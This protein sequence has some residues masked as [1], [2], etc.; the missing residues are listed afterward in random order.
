MTLIQTKQKRAGREQTDKYKPRTKNKNSTPI[1]AGGFLDSWILFDSL[2]SGF[3]FPLRQTL[4]R[5][6]Y[7]AGLD[8]KLYAKV[9]LALGHTFVP[10]PFFHL[11]KCAW[12]GIL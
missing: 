2:I 8:Q 3:E 7:N 9:L 10:K 11:K 6:W 1:R 12:F 5:V 4:A